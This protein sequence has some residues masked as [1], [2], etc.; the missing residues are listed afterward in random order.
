LS[1]SGQQNEDPLHEHLV[2]QYL[3]ALRGTAVAT[4][5]DCRLYRPA[6]STSIRAHVRAPS[7]QLTH[8]HVPIS[9][10]AGLGRPSA[11]NIQNA[12]MKA[13]SNE[14]EKRGMQQCLI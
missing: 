11:G 12:A 6:P 4:V 3:P 1:L 5:L 10:H 7:K 14:D 9:E 13:A 8:E 2:C